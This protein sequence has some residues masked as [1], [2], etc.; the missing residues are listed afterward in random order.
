MSLS[1]N[2]FF[3]KMGLIIVHGSKVAVQTDGANAWKALVL[4][5]ACCHCPITLCRV[6][7]TGLPMLNEPPAPPD[8]QIFILSSEGLH[9]SPAQLIEP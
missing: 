6:A 1:L 3:C 5:L 9:A 2:F 4:G 8:G 7:T